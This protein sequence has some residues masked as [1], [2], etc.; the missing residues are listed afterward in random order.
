[1][2]NDNAVKFYEY[3]FSRNILVGFVVNKDCYNTIDV[4]DKNVK[5]RCID[6]QKH[7]MTSKKNAPAKTELH[8]S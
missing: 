4:K 7:S 8:N 5:N 2:D 3:L 6:L 1:M